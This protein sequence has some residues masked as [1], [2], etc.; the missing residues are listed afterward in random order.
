MTINL[1]IYK[2][3]DTKNSTSEESAQ[4]FY[5]SL[6]Q[7]LQEVPAFDALIVGD[8]AALQF[9]MA[10]QEELF[11]GIPIAFEGVNGI[12]ILTKYDYFCFKA[13][14]RGKTDC[15]GVRRYINR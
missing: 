9:A 6:K 15:G 1:L 11:H 12:T 10:Y 4:L 3:M 13:V 2:F 7:Y 8:D 14:S 5:Q